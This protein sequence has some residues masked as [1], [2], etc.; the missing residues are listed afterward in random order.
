MRGA[1]MAGDFSRDY[2]S[3]RPTDVKGMVVICKILAARVLSDMKSGLSAEGLQ[4]FTRLLLRMISAY[5]G[6]EVMNPCGP[7]IIP[8]MT[9]RLWNLFINGVEFLLLKNLQRSIVLGSRL[10][11]YREP[12]TPPIALMFLLPA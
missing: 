12:H 8:G 7:S 3:K 5:A 2:G 6:Y 11:I 1:E 9:G 4:Y 10:F